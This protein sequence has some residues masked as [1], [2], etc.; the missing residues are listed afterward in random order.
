M[1]IRNVEDCFKFRLL[2]M[3]EPDKS[4]SERSLEIAKERLKEAE[5]AVSIGIF[6]YVILQAHMAMF[7]AARNDGVQEK[8]HYAI[9]VYLKEKYA[10]RIPLQVVNLLN[11]HRTERHEALY[12]LDYKPGKDDAAVATEDAKMFIAEVKKQLGHT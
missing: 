2:R 10:G 11:I 6:P 1:E 12:G 5:K 4:K 3:I 8:S 9:F 7:H